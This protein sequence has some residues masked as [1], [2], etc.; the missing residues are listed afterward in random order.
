[1]SQEF[2]KFTAYFDEEYKVPIFSMITDD[3]EEICDQ[4]IRNNPRHYIILA[5]D[6]DEHADIF[7]HSGKPMIIFSDFHL[8]PHVEHL[9]QLH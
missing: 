4:I 7:A 8:R 5:G 3:Q 9:S 2:Y 6:Y 1:M